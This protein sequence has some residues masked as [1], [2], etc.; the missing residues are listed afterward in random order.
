MPLASLAMAEQL[1][2]RILVTLRMVKLLGIP[3]QETLR[4]DTSSLEQTPT[5]AT[6]AQAASSQKD[7]NHAMTG[8]VALAA[9]LAAPRNLATQGT[10]KS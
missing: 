5:L 6:Q 4:T 3:I 1:G 9:S 10:K 2:I 7:L 8:K